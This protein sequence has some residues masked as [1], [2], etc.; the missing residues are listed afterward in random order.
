[1]VMQRKDGV[2]MHA[3]GQNNLMRLQ[4]GTEYPYYG[5]AVYTDFTPLDPDQF[6]LDDG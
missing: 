5:V 4:P 3:R 1:M 2:L 6:P